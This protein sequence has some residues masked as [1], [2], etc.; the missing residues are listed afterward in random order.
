MN[1]WALLLIA[2]AYVGLLFA[3]AWWGDRQRRPLKIGSANWIYALSLAVYCTSWTFYGAVGSAAGNGWS[4]API[5]LGPILVF[6]LLPTLLKRIIKVASQQNVTSIADFLAARYG[7]SQSV[8]VVATLVCLMAVVPYLA[9]QLKAVD[10]SFRILAADDGTP[11][12][13]DQPLLV[14]MLMAGFAILFGARHLSRAHR[15][16]GMVNAVAFESIVKF[17]ALAAIG[18]Y[19]I[20]VLYPGPAAL[21]EVSRNAGLLAPYADSWKTP[22]FWVQTLLAACAIVCLPRQF[23][24]MVVENPGPRAFDLARPVFISYLLL[25]CVFVVPIALAGN[26]L[27]GALIDPDTFVLALPLEQGALALGTFAYVGG[28][29]AATAMVIVSTVATSTMVSNELVVPYLLRGNYY[30]DKS[31]PG[32]DRVIINSRRLTIV[33][34]MLSGYVFYRASGGEEHLAQ[35]GLLSF[36]AIAQLAPPLLL[37][38]LWQRAGGRAAWTGLAVGAALWAYTLALP[39]LLTD[40]VSLLMHGP[41]GIGWLRPQALLGFDFGDPL[42]HG[43]AWSL[44][45]NSLCLVLISL[46]GRRSLAERI[47]AELFLGLDTRGDEHGGLH[48]ANASIRDVQLLLERFLGADH[49][50]ATFARYESAYAS[51]PAATAQAP[52]R[53]VAHSERELAGAIGTASARAVFARAFAGTRMSFGDVADI[54]GGTAGELHLSRRLLAST[55]ENVDQGVSVVDQELRITAWNQHYIDLF[56][57]PEDFI[58]GGKPIADIIRFNAERG[59]CGPGDVDTHVARRVAYLEAGTPHQYER[60]RADGRVIEI[61]GRPMPGDGFVTSFSDITEHKRVQAELREMNESLETLVTERTRELDEARRIAEAANASKTRFLDAASHDLLQPLNAAKLFASAL[62]EKIQQTEQQGTLAK[63]DGALVAAEEIIATLNEVSR[64]DARRVPVNVEEFDLGAMM[65]A[66]TEEF[67]LLAHAQGLQLRCVAS[68]LWTRSDRKLLRRILQNFLSN[69]I[70]YTPQGRVPAKNKREKGIDGRT[71]CHGGRGVSGRLSRAKSARLCGAGGGPG[72]WA[73]GVLAVSGADAGYFQQTDEPGRRHYRHAGGLIQHPGLYFHLQRLVL[74]CGHKL[75]ARRRRQLVAGH[76][77]GVVRRC[78]GV[79]QLRR[80]AANLAG[81]FRTPCAYSGPGG[82]R[83][84]TTRC[85][86]AQRR[87]LSLRHDCSPATPWPRLNWRG[88]FS[89]VEI[90]LPHLRV[91][92]NQGAQRQGKSPCEIDV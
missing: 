6:L 1:A 43:A 45:G 22:S 71:H 51:L 86:G 67:Q 2:L 72:L 68:R 5:Y 84:R 4:F 35:Y 21:L 26:L 16:Q 53:L 33:G 18:V 32:L 27:P 31:G 36:T 75:V 87:S 11:L 70:R 28:L 40:D 91:E 25:V 65:Q 73:G 17:V 49:T 3:I 52:A 38:L 61:R 30:A 54:V 57:Y 42:I 90:T 8:A 39:A 46:L 83:A 10:A 20:W 60:V 76:P 58:H 62:A 13:F 19:A 23:H 80:R 15:H 50:E 64:I 66:L 56:E 78:R 69:A 92:P 44:G 82:E 63:I 85:A 59:L 29:S 79:D 81:H 9:L 89:G 47:Q 88:F 77:A 74:C 24:L 34:L 41:A 7:K 14:A 55:L 48:S 37:G 12:P